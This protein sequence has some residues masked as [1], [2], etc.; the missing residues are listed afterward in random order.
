MQ[1]SAGGLGR[2]QPRPLR[3]LSRV[4][5]R[6]SVD[7]GADCLACAHQTDSLVTT[8]LTTKDTHMFR[9]DNCSAE[10]HQVDLSQ[11]DSIK[12]SISLPSSPGALLAFAIVSAV[13]LGRTGMVRTLVT[14]VRP[15]RSDDPLAPVLRAPRGGAAGKRVTT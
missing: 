4:R 7:L 14:V 15:T 1:S 9:N 8:G 3:S 5:R 2:R 13:I 12:V 10:N 6:N 11:N